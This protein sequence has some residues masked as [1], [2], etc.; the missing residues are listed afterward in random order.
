MRE[1][2]GNWKRPKRDTAH[3]KE[4]SGL[5]EK[6]GKQATPRQT[7]CVINLAG[8]TRGS[9]PQ[10]AVASRRSAPALSPYSNDAGHAGR[11]IQ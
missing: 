10:Y 7:T 6:T 4:G 2:L 9:E 8:R 11:S 1:Y 3:G 5:P